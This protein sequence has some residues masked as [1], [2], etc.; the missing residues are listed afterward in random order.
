MNALVPAVAP[1]A[2]A[3]LRCRRVPTVKVK[4]GDAGDVDR[5][6]AVRDAVGPRV[7]LRVDANGAWDVDT[8][9][10]AIA[11][12]AA[13]TSSSSSSRWR[14]SRTWPPSAGGSASR[15][16]RRVR[17]RRRR[18]PPPAPA[19]RRRRG[20]AEG[21]AARRRRRRARG[22]RGRRRAGDRVVDVRDVGGARRRPGPRRRPARP[23]VRLRA[24]DRRRC[25]AATW[26]TTRC[27]PSTACSTV[28]RP[29][30]DAGAA[31]PLRGRREGRRRA[32]PAEATTGSLQVGG[33]A[34]AGDAATWALSPMAATI[35]S[36]DARCTCASRSPATDQHR[37]RRARPDG[38]TAAPAR[39][40]PARR[41]AS[42][43][44]SACSPRRAA[45]SSASR[46]SVANSGCAS[47]R[48]R[49]AST[50]IALD[51]GGQLLVGIRRGRP[52]R[53]R[54]RCPATRPA[55]PAARPARA[56]RAA[57]RR[58]SRPPMRVADVGGRRRR[59]SPMA[60][61]GR[62]EVERRRPTPWPGR[63][64]ATTSKR[65]ARCAATGSH[66]R[67]RLGEPVDQHEP[68]RGLRR[69]R[70]DRMTPARRRHRPRWPARWSTSGPGPGSRTP[71]VA[72]GSRSTPLALALA[73]DA[74]MRRARLPRRA[75][76][77][78]LRPRRGQGVG[79]A[80]GRAVHV[81]DGGG[82]LPPGGAGG[83]PRPGPA[84]RLHRRPP[85]R[86][87]RHRRRPGRR[88]ARSCTATPCAGSPRSAR[89]TTARRRRATGGRSRRGRSAEAVG[90][91]A[92]PVHLNLAVP[93]AARAH[94][95]AARRRAGPPRR[96]A[97][98]RVAPAPRRAD[99]GRR[100]P[101]GLARRR[102]A[103]GRHRRRVGRRRGPRRR[104]SGSPP[105]PAGRCSPTPSPASAAGPH[106]V[107]DL[108]RHPA[109]P[110][111]RPTRLQP[112]LVRPLRRATHR[113]GRDRLARRV[114]P[115]RSSSTPTAP[116]STRTGPRRSGSSPIPRPC[117]S[118]PC[119]RH[120]AARDR[121]RRGWTTW[122][123]AE[124]AGAAALDDLLDAWDEPFEG[125]VA[126]DL[127]AGLPDGAT[128]V[129]GSSMPVRDVEAFARPRARPALPRQPGRERHR[130]LRVHR[131][132][133]G[134][135]RRRRR[136]ARRRPLRRPDAS[137]TT[138]A[139]SSAPPT[140]GIDATFVVRRQRRRRDLL[141]PAP[142]RRCREHFETLFGTPHGVDLV[143]LCRGPRRGRRAGHQGRRPR[144]RRCTR[145]SPPAAC[146]S[147][148]CPPTGR[149]TSPATA[150]PPGRRR[151]R[152]ADSPGFGA[153]VAPLIR[154]IGP[155]E[156]RY[157][158]IKR[159]GPGPA[160][161][162]PMG[163][164]RGSWRARSA[165]IH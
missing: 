134:R 108:R 158:R 153:S 57:R 48:S 127:V 79:P 125:R 157:R 105:P 61:G 121:R 154:R 110:R 65:S 162:P 96:P 3:A 165:V 38:P 87:A 66:D 32:G 156:G 10:A 145:P 123:A 85:A 14:R 42:A 19:R 78:V 130:R 161:M 23:A 102:H 132:R 99:A 25:S 47:Q 80:G 104:S 120:P 63:S 90:P 142:G 12:L 128:L 43:R 37:H 136:R 1:D 159:R 114:V 149:R 64:S 44:P 69:E 101:A 141:V 29:V 126:R 112:D 151:T 59:S 8:A 115:A 138:P 55:A 34:G 6:A 60:A 16:R 68:T 20:G 91:P 49:N 117:C 28:R 72:P 75:V 52:L 27:S 7:A 67:S 30:P 4:V 13:S 53:R 77:R 76:G 163:T 116:G 107:S 137:S 109:R 84:G 11:R 74:R 139:A 160:R 41:R 98:G 22:R 73:G 155:V 111:R 26:W 89:P 152:F 81:G 18:R 124:A 5:V 35:R 97:V 143:A 103:P 148:S 119:R 21:P 113:Q 17:P 86:A 82:Q 39:P 164:R 100:R 40:C 118:T 147:W 54:R 71:C 15:R 62:L 33:V 45:R 70:D 24:R 122:L 135:R 133:R 140:R 150:G 129:V 58:Q 92:G 56:G 144:A 50:P 46:V 93:R 95:R 106:A 83:P 2:A 94:R 88:P 146:G 31:R 131:P 36:A 9:V 51:V